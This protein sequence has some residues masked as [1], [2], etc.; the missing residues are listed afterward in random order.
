M[1]S[2]T[3]QG[4]VPPLSPSLPTSPIL[5]LRRPRPRRRPLASMHHGR[6]APPVCETRRVVTQAITIPITIIIMSPSPL[7]LL[8]IICQCHIPRWNGCVSYHHHHHSRWGISITN[9]LALLLLLVLLLVLL[10]VL[11][12]L[13]VLLQHPLRPLQVLQIRLQLLPLLLLLARYTGHSHHRR[14]TIT[15]TETTT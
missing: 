8:R 15:P 4:P 11:L 6:A 3:T 7:P 10:P 9:K 13:L 1:I 12:L 5:L 14:T 2:R